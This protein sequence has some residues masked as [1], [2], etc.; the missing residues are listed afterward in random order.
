MQALNYPVVIF[1]L[2]PAQSISCPPSGSAD[3]SNSLSPAV[4][5]LAS[6]QTVLLQ[7]LA[8]V[9][10]EGVMVVGKDK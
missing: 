6:V 1:V 5:V 2:S 4:P 3:E 9:V 10:K 8:R 7:V